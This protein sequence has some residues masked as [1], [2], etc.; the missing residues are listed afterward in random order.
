MDSAQRFL[1]RKQLRQLRKFWVEGEEI[2]SMASGFMTGR[3]VFIQTNKR[4]VWAPIK[5]TK[6]RVKS[7]KNK[8][9]Q[10]LVKGQKAAIKVGDWVI[11][12]IDRS[13]VAQFAAKPNVIP[14]PKRLFR[15]KAV[16]SVAKPAPNRADNARKARARLLLDKGQISQKEYDWMIK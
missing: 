8:P 9:I 5:W 14:Q 3:G 6:R 1:H 12:R 2:E 13:R 16:A 15:R 10:V 11:H 4:Q 7:Q